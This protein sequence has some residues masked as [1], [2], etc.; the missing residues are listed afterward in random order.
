MHSSRAKANYNVETWYNILY[1]WILTHI[2]NYWNFICSR[3]LSRAIFDAVKIITFIIFHYFSIYYLPVVFFLFDRVLKIM[4]E[5][6]EEGREREVSLK[7]T[8]VINSLIRLRFPVS[9][10]LFYRPRCSAYCCIRVI[11][12]YYNSFTYTTIDVRE[13]F[14]GHTWRTCR[15]ILRAVLGFPSVF[16]GKTNDRDYETP[17]KERA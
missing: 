17:K 11:L 13:S 1:I 7:I 6:R 8:V 10:V 9:S 12:I 15:T 4:S 3:Y 16:F 5:E 2:H 14:A